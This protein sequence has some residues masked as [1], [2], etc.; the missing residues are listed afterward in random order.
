[1]TLD[2]PSL[3]SWLW[4]SAD[5]LRGSIDSSDFKNYIFGLLF[6][7]RANDVFEEETEKLVQEENWDKEDAEADPDYHRFFLPDNARWQTIIEKTENIGEAIDEAL[8]SIEEENT[9]LEGVMTAVHFG[10]KEVLSDSVLQR[11]LNHFNKYSLKNKDLYT[12]DLLGDAYEYLIKMF[13]DDAGKKGGEFYT[14]KGVVRLIVQLIKPEPKNKIYDPTCGSG[15]MLVES[16]RYIIEQ[17]G[18]KSGLLDASLFGQEKNLGTWAICKINMILHNYM[19]ADIKKGCTL[20]TP[21]HV[22]NDELMIF[23]RVIANPPFSQN[24]W[25]D[26]VEVDLKVK[27]DGKEIAPNYAKAVSDPYGRFQYGIPPRGY[28]DLAFFQHMVSVLNQNGRMGIVLPHGVLFRGGS[29]GKIREGVLKDDILETVVGLPSKLFYNTGI[30]A[31]ILIVNKSKPEHLKNK[32]IFIDAS[33]HFK[34]G[35]NQNRLEDEHVK[36]IVDAYDA[37]E[38]I[39]KYMRVVDMDEIKENDFNLNIARYIDTSEEEEPVDL[40]ATLASIK[41]IEAEEKEIDAKLTGFLKEF[42]L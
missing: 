22:Q 29:E 2:L 15:G 35:K 38:E 24:K 39:D 12:P 17:G 9:S 36:K 14:P 30:P 28:A 5:I 33:Q 3:E 10:N 34:E 32:V 4:G 20:G 11:L 40:V 25:W 16:A 37:G 21:K 42:G 8:A 13:A 18:K 1:M 19:D 26:A 31:S 41:A 7:K 6:L 23:D 27:E